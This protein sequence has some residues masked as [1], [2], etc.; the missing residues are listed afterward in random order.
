MGSVVYCSKKQDNWGVGIALSANIWQW[1]KWGSRYQP[2]WHGN[3]QRRII[4]E[5]Q[6]GQ[7]FETS[8][9]QLQSTSI[10]CYVVSDSAIQQSSVI[11]SQANMYTIEIYFDIDCEYLSAGN[12]TVFF[13]TCL[14]CF[15]I[16]ALSC[17]FCNLYISQASY[18]LSMSFNQLCMRKVAE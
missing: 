3:G 5:E 8:S 12:V 16:V 11:Q 4:P 7:L 2:G 9:T 10:H 15:L 14:M 6:S 13:S 18:F 1:S 17:L